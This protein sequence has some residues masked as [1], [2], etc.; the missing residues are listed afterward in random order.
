MKTKVGRVFLD[1]ILK[2]FG[3]HS[4]LKKILNKNTVKVSYS[5]LPNIKQKI[6]AHN[7]K[8][9]NTVNNNINE[10]QRKCNCTGIMGT[11]PMNG[12]CLTSNIIYKAE[13]VA[14]NSPTETY[15]GLT[16][17]TFKKRFY[18]H[19]RSFNVRDLEHET[20]L[21]NHV[22]KLKD[23]NENFTINWSILGKAKPFNQNTRKC[24]LCIKEKFFIIFQ[25]ESA[26]LNQRSELFSTCRHRTQKL[27]K[28]I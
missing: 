1:L 14:D 9:R 6:V 16:S 13:V 26:S 24:R 28:N 25:P 8:I 19:R 27:L 4:T 22:W 5:C 20:E 12:N 11:C 18:G 3:N 17:T 2:H 10:S 21:S 23:R 7:T 15:T